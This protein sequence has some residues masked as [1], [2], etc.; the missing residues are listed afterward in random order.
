MTVLTALLLKTFSPLFSWPLLSALGVVGFALFRPAVAARP[1]VRV[2]SFAVVAIPTLLLMYPAVLLFQTLGGR[3]EALLGVPVIGLPLAVAALATGLLFPLLPLPQL[4]RSWLLPTAMATIAVVVIG[5]TSA[6]SGFDATQPKPNMVMYQLD[7]Q[8]RSASWATA[9]GAG[10]GFGRDGLIDAW[11]SQ[12]FGEPEEAAVA[13]W[14]AAPSQTAPGYRARAEVAPLLPPRLEIV[15]NSVSGEQRT[16]RVRLSSPRGAPNVRMH[17]EATVTA[18][19][20]AGRAADVS[21]LNQDGGVWIHYLALP[22]AGIEIELTLGSAAP[23]EVELHDWS[24]GLPARAG[25]TIEARPSE[26]M[27]SAHDLAD[28]TMVT[29]RQR[30]E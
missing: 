9:G 22:P 10:L 16:L 27:T 18:A 7:E 15:G 29:T 2:A 13:A 12:F 4:S 14:S 17:V 26:M 21:G 1:W 11:T 5:W 6:T 3:L 23:F 20:I 19:S 25:F 24:Q 30:I 28:T 8:T